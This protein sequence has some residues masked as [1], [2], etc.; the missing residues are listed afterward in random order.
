M[1]QTI[2]LIVGD[3]VFWAE[4]S[5]NNRFPTFTYNIFKG[6]FIG[7]KEDGQLI[8][9][10]I[11]ILDSSRIYPSHREVYE[12]AVAAFLQQI[13]KFQRHELRCP[14]CGEHSYREK[15]IEYAHNSG[16]YGV[17]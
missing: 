1:V 15:G 5:E 17:L 6:K 4:I 16:V 3:S 2:Q 13:Q 8:A 14:H 7:L 9:G 12:A 11:D 10:D